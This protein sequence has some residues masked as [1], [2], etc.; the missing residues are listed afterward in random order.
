MDTFYSTQ[1]LRRL[2]QKVASLVETDSIP[3]R[4]E[5]HATDGIIKFYTYVT[6]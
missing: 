6:N 5:Y 3:F 4:V 2:P 1:M